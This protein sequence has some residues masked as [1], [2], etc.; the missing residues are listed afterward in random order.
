MHVYMSARQEVSLAIIVHMYTYVY[1][2]MH[3]YIHVRTN[4]NR[5][6]KNGSCDSHAHVHTFIR[7][8]MRTYM[9][10]HTL[11]VQLKVAPVT[12]VRF[13]N[14]LFLALATATQRMMA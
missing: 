1:T 14:V 5:S 7:S 2:Y 8:Y 11:T 3:A 13:A 10:A 9:C 12:V 6:A 4:L